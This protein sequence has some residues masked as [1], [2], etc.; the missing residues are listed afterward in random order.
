MLGAVAGVGSL[1][2]FAL[3]RPGKFR[4]KMEWWKVEGIIVFVLIWI[5]LLIVAVGAHLFHS[6][7]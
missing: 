4:N 2:L 6:L 7:Q 3:S 1:M 5:V